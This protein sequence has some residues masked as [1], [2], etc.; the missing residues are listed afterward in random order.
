[1]FV[2]ASEYLGLSP[3]ECIVVEDAVA[4]LEAGKKG[5]MDQAAIGDAVSSNL[6]TYNLNTLSE[7]L[8]V[9]K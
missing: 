1:V 2:K 8:T 6:A 9:V 5:G 4:G 7:L 3:E